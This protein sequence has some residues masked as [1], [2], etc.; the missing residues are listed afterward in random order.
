MSMWDQAAD[1]A[2][3][4]QD[5]IDKSGSPATPDQKIALAQVWAT[6]SVAQELSRMDPG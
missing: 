2:I 3:E 6:L 5:D 4:A 1:A